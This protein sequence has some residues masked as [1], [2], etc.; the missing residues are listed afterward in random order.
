MSSPISAQ[1]WAL[2]IKPC[3]SRHWCSSENPATVKARLPPPPKPGSNQHWLH[4]SF[5]RH[6]DCIAVFLPVM[7][8]VAITQGLTSGCIGASQSPTY[9]HVPQEMELQHVANDSPMGELSNYRI[10]ESLR[11]EKLPKIP[12]SNPNPSH[13]AH[14]PH[15]SVPHLHS[16][17]I[18]PGLVTPPLPGQSVQTPF[19]VSLKNCTKQNFNIWMQMKSLQAMK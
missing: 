15:P 10:V 11:L 4:R 16:Y 3:K 9:A 5:Q 12:K 7:I 19:L 2:T 1:A 13:H 17:G 14:W 18:P 6:W 8:V